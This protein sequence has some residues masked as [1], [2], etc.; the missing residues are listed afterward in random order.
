MLCFFL[1][2]GKLHSASGKLSRNKMTI[3]QE[4][5]LCCEAIDFL[6][7]SCMYSNLKLSSTNDLGLE[8]K[9]NFLAL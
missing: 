2:L 6:D 1:D 7:Q 9:K 8:I 3:I 5:L 4:N